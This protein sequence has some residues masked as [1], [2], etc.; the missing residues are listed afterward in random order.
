MTFSVISGRGL[1]FQYIA[2]QSSRRGRVPIVVICITLCL[3]N[4]LGHPKL[5]TTVEFGSNAPTRILNAHGRLCDVNFR[6]G[7]MC[8]L[9]PGPE[10]DDRI[11]QRNFIQ[12]C[13]ATIRSREPSLSGRDVWQTLSAVLISGRIARKDHPAQPKYAQ[14]SHP[15]HPHM[16]RALCLLRNDEPGPDPRNLTTVIYRAAPTTCPPARGDFFL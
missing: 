14:S 9:S 4:G 16:G 2:C 3:G 7:D 11:C 6:V 1:G 5:G 15:Q 12:G 10:N 8:T 13:L